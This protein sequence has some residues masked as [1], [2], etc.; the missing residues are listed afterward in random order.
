[1]MS[2]K[3]LLW[4]CL[5]A[6]AL[7][8]TGLARASNLYA[9]YSLEGTQ[10]LPSGV[11]N[12]RFLAILM[13]MDSR[14][15]SDGNTI[16]LGDRLNKPV[17]WSDVIDAQD[18]D[19]LKEIARSV[20]RDSNIPESGTAGRATGVVKTYASVLTPAL[21][22][23]VTD[24]MTIALA[25]PVYRVEAKVDTGF[26]K[27]SQGQTF[28]NSL[29][30]SSPA[31][32]NEVADKLNKA[33]QQKLSRLDYEPLQ[34][35][36]THAIGDMLFLTKY[37]LYGSDRSSLASKLTVTFPTGTTA[38]PDRVFD[39]NTGDG[40]FKLG[41]GLIWDHQLVAKLRL[42]AYGGYTAQMPHSVVKRLPVSSN[43]SLSSASKEDRVEVTQKWGD[44]ISAG[45]TV[46]YPIPVAGLA[47]AAGYSAQYQ[48]KSRF[49]GPSENGRYRLL[50][51]LEP[52]QALQAMTTAVGF[53]TIDWYRSG[54]FA[55]PLQVNLVYSHPFWGRN[56]PNND[57]MA[58]ELV[59]FF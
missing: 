31:R 51:D 30:K 29:C 34:A 48:S 53:S 7:I 59:M 9:P 49:G 27:S 43:D 12:P 57:V 38:N 8:L 3:S 5:T 10:V 26:I 22:Y 28:I 20:L 14:F 52:M 50:E 4:L 16:P 2:S 39:I 47:L 11:R 18:D 54:K 1:M 45:L 33:I 41:A 36:S 23:G 6:G 25:V 58:G 37:R 15:D 32:C 21:A 46:E 55:F 24:R 35:L 13:S 44:I 19:V 42:T 17:G 56:L 40:R